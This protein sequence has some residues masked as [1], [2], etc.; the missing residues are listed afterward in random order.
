MKKLLFVLGFLFLAGCGGGG[1]GV[2]GDKYADELTAEEVQKL[3]EYQ[4]ELS[5]GAQS[6]MCSP[7][8]TATSQSL[9]EC[10]TA[11]RGHC[12]VKLYEECAEAV[13]DDPCKVFSEVKCT[14][15]IAQCAVAQ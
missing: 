5:G 1:S 7:E 11:T 14:S 2:D 6:K 9:D 8:I 3:C 13:G 10:L 4:V 15:V 12:Q